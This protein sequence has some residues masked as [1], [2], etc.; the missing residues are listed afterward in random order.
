MK[1]LLVGN[2]EPDRQHSMLS[3][4][5]M[6]ELG[7]R[8]A[9]HFVSVI[10]PEPRLRRLLGAGPGLAKWLGY[11]DKFVLFPA[12][13]RTAAKS[14]DV[15]HVCDH[16]YA[17]YTRY[18]EG[19]P[20]VVTCHD[21][22]AARCA[23]GEFSEI[24]TRWSG[25]R[26]QNMIVNG[27]AQAQHVV[28]DSDST[29]HD[30]RRLCNLMPSATSV[31]HVALNFAYRP[32]SEAEKEIRLDRLG[33]S[34]SDRFILHVG[35]N[36]WYK[37]QAGVVRIF[38]KIAATQQACGIG[39]VMV[40]GGLTASLRRV[41]GNGGSQQRVR[42]LSHVEPEDLRA[43]YSSATALLFPS[44]QEGFGWPIIEA[45]ACGCPVFASDR[46][47]MTEVGGEGAVYFDPENHEQAANMILDN[48][49]HAS[50]MR[51][52]GFANIRR[53]SVE[54]MVA[55]YVRAYAEAIKAISIPRSRQTIK[56]AVASTADAASFY[57]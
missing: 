24:H 38:Q 21:L 48:L 1:V 57:K 12:R 20:T 25:R 18:L 32:V 29:A 19:I 40:S 47:P 4:S 45:Q 11:L 7:L 30:V 22:I 56:S 27:L 15:V 26:Y 10:R 35:G 2:Y 37:N 49:P 3:F 54:K 16:A 55:G 44:L 8:H 17:P 28:C 5:K 51:D 41:I 53:F 50:R 9:G 43:L 36:T 14:A 42:V 13:L 39:L 31:V 46:P 23:L 34:R 52:A 6:L 33:L